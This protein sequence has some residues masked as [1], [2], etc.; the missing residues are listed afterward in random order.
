MSLTLGPGFVGFHNSEAFGGG[1]WAPGTDGQDGAGY[2]NLW[3]KW[4]DIL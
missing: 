4:G 1:G 3:N 2:E